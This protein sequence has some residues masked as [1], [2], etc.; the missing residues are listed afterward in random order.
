MK[1]NKFMSEERIKE[2]SKRPF[3]KI[4]PQRIDLMRKGVCVS[5]ENRIDGFRDSLSH[6]EYQISG[7]CQKCQDSVFGNGVDKK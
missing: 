3:A 2:L 1:D 5:C 6:K 4:F 7:L